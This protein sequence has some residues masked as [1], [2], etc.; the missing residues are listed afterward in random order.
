MAEKWSIGG[1][2]MAEFARKVNP[3]HY[4]TRARG[5]ERLPVETALG[6][7]HVRERQVA[8]WKQE[9]FTGWWATVLERKRAAKREESWKRG[10][11]VPWCYRKLPSTKPH[12]EKWRLP[13]SPKLPWLP[14]KSAH[15]PPA[16][17]KYCTTYSM[18]ASKVEVSFRSTRIRLVIVGKATAGGFFF[19]G[20]Q[21]RRWAY[22]QGKAVSS[23]SF[24]RATHLA[25]QSSLPIW[26]RLTLV[27]LWQAA[28]LRRSTQEWPLWCILWPPLLFCVL[29][30][31]KE[32]GAFVCFFVFIPITM[33][34]QKMIY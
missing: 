25:P 22:I 7:N 13:F 33:D 19:L 21:L 34:T 5:R 10:K 1:K 9:E 14:W 32:Y 3:H 28:M 20:V 26:F 12:T 11:Y 8:N 24:H 2:E 29:Y 23:S 16:L 15:I 27:L 4:Q 30:C 17:E 31:L 6:E 18:W